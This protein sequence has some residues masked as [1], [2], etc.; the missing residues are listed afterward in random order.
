MEVNIPTSIGGRLE[1]FFFENH[2]PDQQPDTVAVVG[3]GRW[4]YRVKVSFYRVPYNFTISTSSSS[5]ASSSWEYIDIYCYY[6]YYYYQYFIDEFGENM[7]GFHPVIVLVV[8]TGRKNLRYCIRYSE[9]DL[10]M[11]TMQIYI[12]IY[13][14]LFELA[15]LLTYPFFQVLHA[16]SGSTKQ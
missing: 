2:H 16:S 9:K 12:Y 7:G 6:C 11:F 10:P 14:I 13:I 5:S 4:P 3:P 1:E 15:C 8:A